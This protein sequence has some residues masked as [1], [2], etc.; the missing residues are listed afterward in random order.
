MWIPA[1]RRPPWWSLGPSPCSHSYRSSRSPGW[2]WPRF[3]LSFT[4]SSLLFLS[5]AL[6]LSPAPVSYIPFPLCTRHCHTEVDVAEGGGENR[7]LLPYSAFYQP[8]LAGNPVKIGEA[9]HVS[10]LTRL[11]NR[12][13]EARRTA[14]T[15]FRV[16]RLSLLFGLFGWAR[17]QTTVQTTHCAC[18]S[19]IWFSLFS[20]LLFLLYS[21]SLY[22]LYTLLPFL[23]VSFTLSLACQALLHNAYYPVFI[24]FGPPIDTPPSFFAFFPQ[25]SS[26]ETR[27]YANSLARH[28]HYLERCDAVTAWRG[29]RSHCSGMYLVN[30]SPWTLDN[31]NSYCIVYF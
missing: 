7:L 12:R 21:P 15:K 9:R 23:S 3:L 27:I 24:P 18:E 20:P 19:L 31:L 30:W 4:R 17:L 25:K 28:P 10:T 16:F 22:L 13:E 2:V 11:E 26:R 5:C 29:R 1:T 8:L 14:P 6:F